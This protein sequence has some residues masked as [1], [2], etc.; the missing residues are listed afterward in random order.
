MKPK[1]DKFY[2]SALIALLL[3]A[4]GES[5]LTGALYDANKRE[6]FYKDDFTN[7][8]PSWAYLVRV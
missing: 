1:Y 3:L 4:G 5:F 7:L 6:V 2:V 8:G